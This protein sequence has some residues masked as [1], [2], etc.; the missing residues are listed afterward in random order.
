MLEQPWLA[1]VTSIGSSPETKAFEM[2]GILGA[3]LDIDVDEVANSHEIDRSATGFVTHDRHEALADRL[4]AEPAESADGWER[5]IDA[6]QRVA[7]V[8]APYL[9]AT[10]RTHLV[11]GHGG[12]GTLLLCHLLGLDI[13]RSHD[14]PRQG[15][16]W[17]Y[18]C[19]RQQVLHRWHP[20]DRIEPTIAVESPNTPDVIELLQAHLEFAQDTSPAEHVHALDLS[21]LMTPEITFCTARRG[22]ELL[23][24]GALRDLGDGRSE[25]KSMHTAV[26]ARGQRVGRL[27][28][29]RLVELAQ[30][31][32]HTWVG[33]ETGTMEA[34]APARALYE[35]FGFAQCTPFEGY[36]ANNFSLCMS[37]RL[38]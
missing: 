14:Q 26:S 7:D 32:S 6:Q 38:P 23:G 18:D 9:E 34:F 8:F 28:L 25:I 5:A 12:V 3:H 24:V 37:L 21:S 27:M 4:F 16:Y 22:G 30:S 15:H 1:T 29:E 33:L 13:D 10:G 20:I 2:A 17:A 19:D 36:T 35:S 31:R 11:V